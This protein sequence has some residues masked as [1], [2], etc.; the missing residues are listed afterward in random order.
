MDIKRIIKNVAFIAFVPSV[1]VVGYYGYKAFKKYTEKG[2]SDK[3]NPNGRN[4]LPPTEKRL[5]D[6]TNIVMLKDNVGQEIVFRPT[7]NKDENKDENK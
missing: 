6:S 7:E 2:N 3:K 1:V 4:P 5:L